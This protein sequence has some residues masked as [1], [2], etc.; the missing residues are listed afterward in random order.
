MSSDLEYRV[1]M[2]EEEIRRLNE[3]LNTLEV[4]IEVLIQTNNH[5]STLIKYVVTPLIIILGALIG[6]KITVP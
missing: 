1:R 6:V 4:K 5:L 3:R 2:L